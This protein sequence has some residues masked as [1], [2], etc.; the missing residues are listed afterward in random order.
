MEMTQRLPRPGAGRMAIGMIVFAV[1]TFASAFAV[2][3]KPVTWTGIQ[4]A[5]GFAALG[6]LAMGA[7]MARSTTYPRWAHWTSA[8]IFAGWIL[9]SPWI[10]GSPEVW[11]AEARQNLWMLPWFMMITGITGPRRATGA[12]ATHS[13]RAGTI[14][15]GMSLVM[16]GLLMFAERIADFVLQLGGPNA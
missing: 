10:M 13:T 4:L 1:T 14:L 9:V 2:R 15:V 3:E 6:V 5:T 11:N 7:V 16:G 12:C 8:G